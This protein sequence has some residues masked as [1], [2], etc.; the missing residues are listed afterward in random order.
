MPSRN[1]SKWVSSVAWVPRPASEWVEEL[2]TAAVSCG[3][4]SEELD[5]RDN[6]A[7]MDELR[8][9]AAF[10]G[11]GAVPQIFDESNEEFAQERQE[12]RWALNTEE[13]NAAARTT[14]N[15]HYTDPAYVAA[16][17]TAVR[18][19]G[20]TGGRI[21]EPGCGT[22]TFIGL[23]PEGAQMVGVEL[24]TITANIAARLYPDAEI[25]AESFAD[26]RV[27]GR[28]DAV[29]GNVPFSDAP[30]TDRV[31]NAGGHSMHNH[32]LIKS[33]ALTKPGGIVAA[34][35]SR[36]TLDA[37]NPAARRELTELG[38]LVGACSAPTAASTPRP[39]PSAPRP[40]PEAPRSERQAPHSTDADRQA[41]HHHQQLVVQRNELRRR[42][43]LVRE[44]E[45]RPLPGKP[46]TVIS[47]F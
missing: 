12:L 39:E 3:E 30:L 37:Q 4:V 31:H 36:Y 34:L 15:A 17:W 21:L 33:L 42:P 6:G 5:V 14:I 7:T 28:F 46:L 38:D 1:C 8:Q 40:S 47:H 24:D 29:V 18:E 41:L 32:F 26:T 43:D 19:L 10:S 25:L 16:I 45:T 35:T 44:S 9:L 23:A 2:R 20:F 13:W 11:W 22:G 27:T